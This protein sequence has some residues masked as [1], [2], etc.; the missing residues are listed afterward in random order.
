M[1]TINSISEEKKESTCTV[2]VVWEKV[3]A[4]HSDP[5]AGVVSCVKDGCTPIGRNAEN[6]VPIFISRVECM[7]SPKVAV[8]GAIEPIDTVAAGSCCGEAN[9]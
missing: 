3:H 1:D 2:S 7:V 4:F 9:E 5:T 6:V 8:E